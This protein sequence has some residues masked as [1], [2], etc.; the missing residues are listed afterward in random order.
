[1]SDEGLASLHELARAAGISVEWQD[2]HGNHQVVA[3]EVLKTVLSALDIEADTPEQIAASLVRLQ[4][5]GAD[6]GS[7]LVIGVVRQAMELAV[8]SSNPV[9]HF[10]MEFESGGVVDGVAKRKDE[11]TVV[12]PGISVPGY[13]RLFIGHQHF[14]LAVAPHRCYSMADATGTPH[15][16]EWA[17]AVQIYGLRRRGGMLAA[18]GGSGGIGDFTALGELGKIAAQRGAAA[19]AISPVHAMF[20]ADPARFSPYGPSSRLHINV[21]HID[22]AEVFGQPAVGLAI[23]AL[24]LGH[25]MVRLEQLDLIDW[26]GVAR[27]KLA[28]LHRLFDGFPANVG[29]SVHEEFLRF[30]SEGGAVLEDHARF[31]ALHAWQVSEGTGSSGWREWPVQYQDPAGPAVTAFAGTHA[32]EVSFHAFLQWLADRG[33]ARA[34]GAAREAGMSIG[35]I[36]DLAVGTDPSGSHAW[37]RQGEILARLSPGAPP[38]IYNPHGQAWGIT[39]FSPSAMKRNGYRA[40]IEM[41]RASLKHAGG[42]RIDHALGLSRMWLVPEGSSPRDGAYVNYPFEDMMRLVALESWRLRTVV[43]GE[44]LGTVPEGFNDKIASAGMLGM[45]VMW[46]ERQHW[47]DNAPFKQPVHWSPESVGMTTTHDLPT[48]AGWWV[49]RDLEWRARLGLFADGANQEEQWRVRERDREQLVQAINAAGFGSD[50]VDASAPHAPLKAVFEFIGT[51]NCPLV[52]VPLEDVLALEEQP[53]FP[54]TIDTHPNWRRRIGVPVEQ[55]LNEKQV[56]QRLGALLQA[57][58]KS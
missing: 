27:A 50:K 9:L 29:S 2:A 58:K 44:N 34:Q 36:S 24:G 26:P 48:V 4:Q 21:L 12:V 15:P 37:S 53:N 17:L 32:L 1:M 13:H 54:G 23:S 43:V 19:L 6:S 49:G 5:S 7:N 3:P 22:P 31:E 45:Q 14:T 11:H 52:V 25:E 55:L 38:D 51:A 56:N 41:L 16:R 28:V 10:R 46:F 33:M 18:P 57:R 40:F 30:R 20:S 47:G 35:L 8:P 42:I 39:A